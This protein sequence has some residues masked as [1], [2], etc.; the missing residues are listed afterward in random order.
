M[1]PDLDT[2]LTQKNIRPTAM[3]LL[4][5]DYLLNQ[6]AA[7]SLNNLETYFMRSDRI[8]LYRTLKTFE[9]K[10][11]VHSIDDGSGSVKYAL[12]P[13]DCSTEEHHDL[14]VHFF[15]NQCRETF[16]LPKSHIP[17]IALPENFK[18]EEVNLMVKGICSK[19]TR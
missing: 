15:C 2:T 12:C 1:R 9:E 14:H 8:T 3:R 19:C 5:L 11:L 17:E 18:T 4:V 10:G 7:V 16:C 6:T 13:D